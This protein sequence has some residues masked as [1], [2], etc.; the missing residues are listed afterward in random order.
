M[1]SCLSLEKHVEMLGVNHIQNPDVDA[2]ARIEDALL[3]A[4]LVASRQ[5]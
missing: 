3:T 1:N 5:E 2:P 4:G